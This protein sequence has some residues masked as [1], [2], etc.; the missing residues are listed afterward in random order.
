MAAQMVK[1][2]MS[3]PFAMPHQLL[4]NS[5]VSLELPTLV[6][7]AGSV[8]QGLDGPNPEPLGEDLVPEALG[9]GAW[10]FLI[11]EMPGLYLCKWGK[12]GFPTYGDKPQDP[13]G[14]IS[15]S[16]ESLHRSWHGVTGLRE[17]Q[18]PCA[19]ILGPVSPWVSVLGPHWPVSHAEAQ[20]SSS[21]GTEKCISWV[22]P[23]SPCLHAGTHTV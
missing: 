23:S 17:F 7:H 18:V 11:I 16:R 13:L 12:S 21:P 6:F 14:H 10:F 19:S 2:Y 9:A 22:V 4:I 8:R 15:V 20:V 1:K 5:A 3:L